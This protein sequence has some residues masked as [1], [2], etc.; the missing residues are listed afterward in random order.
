MI[1][2][3]IIPSDLNQGKAE[4]HVGWRFREKRECLEGE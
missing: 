2:K 3:V 1:E 4:N